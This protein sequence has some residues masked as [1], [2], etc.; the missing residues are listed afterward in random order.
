MFL[1]AEIKTEQK[2]LNVFN[3]DDSMSSAESLKFSKTNSG[4]MKRL[5]RQKSLVED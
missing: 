5:R 4:F 2:I 1:S 3:K